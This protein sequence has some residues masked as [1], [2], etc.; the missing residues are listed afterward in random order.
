VFINPKAMLYLVTGEWVEDPTISAEAFPGL[1]EQIV[2]P[3]LEMLDR[4]VQGKKATGG[5]LAGQRKGALIL[6]ASSHDEVGD[7]LAGLPFWSRLNWNVI[8]LQSF[9]SAIERDSKAMENLKT[10]KS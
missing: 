10:A 7:I 8:P 9:R 1:W 2:R 3:S 5:V 4:M 6:A